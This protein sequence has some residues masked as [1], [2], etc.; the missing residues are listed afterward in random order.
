ME[1]L[2]VGHSC[3][4]QLHF[5]SLCDSSQSSLPCH[6]TWNWETCLQLPWPFSRHADDVTHG[7]RAAQHRRIEL[8]TRSFRVKKKTFYPQK[9]NNYLSLS[10][11]KTIMILTNWSCSC[12]KGKF[13]MKTEGGNSTFL[14]Y[15]IA[16]LWMGGIQFVFLNPLLFCDKQHPRGHYKTWY[17]EISDIIEDWNRNNV[18]Q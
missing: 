4:A 7:D 16:T 17:V 15:S 1:G 13:Q 11:L 9:R 3:G 18:H 8:D 5:V 6:L 10:V 12:L 14:P 2:T